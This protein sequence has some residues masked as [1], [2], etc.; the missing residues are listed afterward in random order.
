MEIDDSQES[1]EEYKKIDEYV[2]KKVREDNIIK[3]TDNI[4]NSKDQAS[5]FNLTP[6]ENPSDL[7]D[8]M[9]TSKPNENDQEKHE[10][11]FNNNVMKETSSDNKIISLQVKK[12]NQ[13]DSNFSEISNYHP[14]SKIEEINQN[15]HILANN[16]EMTTIKIKEEDNS[17]E[18]KEAASIDNIVLIDESILEKKF[19]VKKKGQKK[20]HKKSKS[21]KLYEAIEPN[22]VI[23]SIST[24]IDVPNSTKDLIFGEK[25][26]SQFERLKNISPFGNFN[27]FKIFKVII[28]NG[29]DLRQEQFATQLINEFYQIFQLEEVDIWLKPYEILS[30]GDNVGLIECVPNSVSLD[31]LKRKSM[32]T[33]SQFYETYFG[34]KN[35]E[36]LINNYIGYKCAINEFIKSLAGYSLVCYFLQIKDRHNG[37]ILIDDHGHIIHIDFGFMLSNAPG[38]GIQFE[39]APFKLTK[40]FVDVIGGVK[41]ENFSKFRKLLWKYKKLII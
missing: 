14:N 3:A 37:N 25:M 24:Q 41:T 13:N 4:N 2:K 23:E 33:L 40:E 27:T 9:K 35:T 16:N 19:P 31:Y 39:K 1:E 5:N 15:H 21:K 38:K 10:R 26:E 34:P 22:S 17:K 8:L 12:D 11:E 32:N 28:K 18:V 7:K 36:S 29:E 6:I 30:T 20:S